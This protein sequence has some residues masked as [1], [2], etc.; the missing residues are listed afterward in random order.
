MCMEER[1]RRDAVLIDGHQPREENMRK[2]K[3]PAVVP[4]TPLLASLA[5]LS[6]KHVPSKRQKSLGEKEAS[7]RHL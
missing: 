3:G 7:I 2:G 6:G 5:Q 4:L 1:R